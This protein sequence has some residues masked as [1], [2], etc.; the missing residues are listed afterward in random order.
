MILEVAEG[1][2][3]QSTTEQLI[4]KITTTNWGTSPSSP[5][6]AVYI[7]AT[8]VTS[9]VMPTNTPT[10]AADVITLSPLKSLSNGYIYRV[11]VT[12]TSGSN[13]FECHFNVSCT[14]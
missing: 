6:V 11:E 3:Y 12:F 2:R 13:V 1:M 10:A 9:T 14:L 4:Y 8:D 7:G 5:V